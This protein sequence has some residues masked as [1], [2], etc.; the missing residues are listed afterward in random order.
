MP[1]FTILF[2]EEMYNISRLAFGAA[3]DF[4]Q[5]GMSTEPNTFTEIL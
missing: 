3:N 4:G 2:R 1:F 5:L